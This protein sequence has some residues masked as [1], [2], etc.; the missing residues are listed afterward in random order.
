MPPKLGARQAWRERADPDCGKP[1]C[2]VKGVFAMMRRTAKAPPR[3]RAITRRPRGEASTASRV[4]RKGRTRGDKEVINVDKDSAELAWPR[5]PR[6]TPTSPTPCARC[7]PAF[8]D[9]LG[10]LPVHYCADDFMDKA[11]ST[12]VVD[13]LVAVRAAQRGEREAGRARLPSRTW[14]SGGLG[15]PTCWHG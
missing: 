3:T 15:P 14:T 11:Q 4:P 6:T 13:A 10:P 2:A 5:W 1:V 12:R 9:A 8:F 7:R